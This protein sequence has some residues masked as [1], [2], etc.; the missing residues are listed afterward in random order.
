MKRKR[1][2]WLLALVPLVA[3]IWA[4]KSA[5]SWR[6]QLLI[7]QSNA[8]YPFSIQD[9]RLLLVES[10]NNISGF[11][12][13]DMNTGQLLW[14]RDKRSKWIAYSSQNHIIAVVRSEVPLP[15]ELTNLHGVNLELCDE[16]DGHVI[17][18]LQPGSDSSEGRLLAYDFSTDETE[19]RVVTSE[20]LQRWNIATGRLIVNHKWPRAKGSAH[21][22]TAAFFRGDEKILGIVGGKVTILDAR[23]GTTIRVLPLN[24]KSAPYTNSPNFFTV[25]PDDYSFYESLDST[26]SSRIFRISDGKQ[27]W[28]SNDWPTFSFDGQISYIPSPNGLDVFEAH[29][30]R[31]LRHLPGPSTYGF[32]PS[33][34]GN[35]L[36]EARDGKI[37][38][39]RAR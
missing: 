7:I 14:K 1:S 16:R 4:M 30:G 28:Q 2:L 26:D 24:Y 17:R 38:R 9:G 21:I 11:A 23:N 18:A 12:T 20:S 27:L 10:V 34:D 39:W 3:L 25:S 5:A 8:D 31:L 22:T 36:Y 6:P 29:T 37:Y 13:W 32:D 33:A 15:M 19:F 35:W